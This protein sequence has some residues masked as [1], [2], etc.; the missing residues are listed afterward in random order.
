MM[1]ASLATRVVGLTVHQQLESKFPTQDLEVLDVMG[2]SGVPYAVVLP[3][4]R[5]VTS[6]GTWDIQ[7]Q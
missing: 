6:T 4:D 7:C 3:S 1:E 5:F 2:N